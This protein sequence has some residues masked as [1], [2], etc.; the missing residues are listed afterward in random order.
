MDTQA[1]DRTQLEAALRAAAAAAPLVIHHFATWCDPC[2]EELPLLKVEF[3]R[4]AP[5]G[6]KFVAVSWDLFMAPVAPAAAIEACTAFLA[7]HGIA[8]DQLFVFTGSPPELF[9]SQRIE[10]GTVPC[11]EVRARGGAVVAS[12]PHPLFEDAERAEFVAVVRSAAS[13]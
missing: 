3:E 2:A 9:E 10:H 4:L 11:T 8:F 13:A 6:V 12:F 1:V 5:L 7:Q